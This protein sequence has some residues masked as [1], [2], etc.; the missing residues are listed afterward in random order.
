MKKF[1]LKA[2]LCALF[3][4]LPMPAM[5]QIGINIHIGF[6]PP[7]PFAE[8]PAV[9][10]LP[11]TRD[12]YVVPSIDMDLFFWNGWWWRPWQGR[13]Y[14]SRYYDRGWVV[15]RSVPTF[16][17]DVDP[18]WRTHYRNRSWRGHPWY[19][20]RIDQRR[21]QRQWQRWHN[22]RHWDRKQTWGVQNYRPPA[23]SQ[24][25]ELRLKRQQEYR[26]RPDVQQ[27]QQQRLQQQSPPRRKQPS[28][29]QFRHTPD[30]RGGWEGGHRK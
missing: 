26:Q 4:A 19:Y 8:P 30:K 23:E 11:D 2:F 1:F 18:S 15:Y 17:Y 27:Y 10:V 5:A 12:V 13:W 7:I 25:R 16:Y 29:E 24:R 22:D 6:P 3:I 14:R 20:E 9:I 21:L 28:G